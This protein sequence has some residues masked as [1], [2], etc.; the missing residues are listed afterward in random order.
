MS[1]TNKLCK[2][3]AKGYRAGD[4]AIYKERF[5]V[6]ISEAAIKDVF[7]GCVPVIF[8]GRE[9]FINVPADDLDIF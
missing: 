1:E 3:W 7:P 8:D 4:I 9:T 2:S 6:T 5:L